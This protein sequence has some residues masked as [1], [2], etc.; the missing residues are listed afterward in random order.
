MLTSLK[1]I[2]PL[3]I[4]LTLALFTN[5]AYSQWNP[6]TATPPGNNVAAPLN[7]GPQTQEKAG[8]LQIKNGAPTVFF[9]DTD[10][11]LST[12]W[13]LNGDH[14]NLVRLLGSDISAGWQTLPNGYWPLVSSLSTGHLISGGPVVVGPQDAG[15]EGGEVE[16]R[17]SPGNYNIYLD[18]NAGIF[19]VFRNGSELFRVYP[20]G[21]I[22]SAAN[23]YCDINGNNCTKPGGGAPRVGRFETTADNSWHKIA[24]PGTVC[25]VSIDNL[26][27][28]AS[29]HWHQ[30]VYNQGNGHVFAKVSRGHVG[31]SYTC[32]D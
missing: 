30:C 19:R 7:T 8:N 16:L 10:N 13:H 26:G 23:Q 2:G 17:G 3:T 24:E 27:T 5:F 22:G 12:A 25:H 20:D 31:C 4:A 9:G 21:R 11:G 28:V 32:Y 18:N 15:V 14:M 6:P 1:Q 29:N